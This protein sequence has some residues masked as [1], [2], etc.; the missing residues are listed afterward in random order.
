M[1]LEQYNECCANENAGP[2]EGWIVNENAGPQEGW[3]VRSH[4]DW[5]GEQNIPYKGVEP[6]P[7]RRVLK[8]RLTTVCNGPK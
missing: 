3:I 1:V 6:L 5:R 2:Q 8:L 7:N 4:I